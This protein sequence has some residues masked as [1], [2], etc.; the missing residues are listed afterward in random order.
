MIK[1]YIYIYTNKRSKLLVCQ[2]IIDSGRKKRM[3]RIRKEFSVISVYGRVDICKRPTLEIVVVVDTTSNP[4]IF[5][6]L[7]AK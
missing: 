4:F 5:I 7:T 1:R 6:G 2:E 3:Q